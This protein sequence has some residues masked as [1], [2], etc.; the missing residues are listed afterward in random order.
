MALE[1]ILRAM[2]P[3]MLS[4]LAIKESAKEAWDAI[5]TMRMGVARVRKAKAQ[6]LRKEFDNLAFHDGES[7][8]DFAMRLTGL[9][10]NLHILGD[11]LEEEKVVQKFMCVV[12]PR[13]SQIALSIETLMDLDT[14]SVKE[15]TERLKAAEDRLDLGNTGGSGSR[16]L[17]T[18]EE[19]LAHMKKREQGE[20]SSGGGKPA[21]DKAGNGGGNKRR[22]KRHGKGGGKD[23]TSSSGKGAGK[24]K[25]YNCG[26]YGHFAREC[27][28]PRRERKEEANM[29]RAQEE[30]PTL[31]MAEHHVL[32]QATDGVQQEAVFLNEEKVFPVDA[33]SD[34][35]YL[36][37]GASNHM[38]GN[39]SSLTSLD[40]TVKGTVKFGDDSVVEICSK[41]AV[42]YQCK[43]Q[44]HRVL[45]EVYYIPRLRSNIISLGQL[46]ESGYKI[47]IE[48]G[49]LCI[50]DRE[51]LL[52]ARVLRSRN[53]L[54]T[55]ALNLTAPVCLLAKADDM[56]WRWHARYG[57]LHFR[58][59]HDLTAKNMVDGVP[60][61]DRVEKFCDGCALGKQH[62]A[63]FPR[64]SSYR[65]E[66]GLELVHGDLYGPITP[67]TPIGNQYFLLIVDDHSRYMW[68]E[69]LRTKDEAF[70]FFRKI[71]TLAENK[72]DVKLKAFR[73][74]RGGEFNSI[75]FGDYCDEHGIKRYTTAPYSPQQNGVVERRNQT[76]VEMAHSLLKSMRVPAMFWGEAVKTTVHILNR[77]PTRSLDGMTPYEAWHKRRPNVRCL[78][79]FGC[80]A[81]VKKVGPGITKLSDRSTPMV[82]I[83]YEEGAKA[84]RV[85]DPKTHKLHVTRDVVFEE[86]KQWDWEAMSINRAPGAMDT[87]FIEYTTEHVAD[88]APMN[89]DDGAAS[90]SGASPVAPQTA[91]PHTPATPPAAAPTDVEW[92]PPPTDASHDSEGAPAIPD[93]VRCLRHDIGP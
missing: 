83:G 43:N 81:H 31:L 71:K 33:G 85:Y 57:H 79:T 47:V 66:C 24:G 89:G 11:K 37:T 5:K 6:S 72:H 42:M 52:L 55:L 27:C 45:T 12:P 10:N 56:A 90:T 77:A 70:R 21:G 4:T 59:L 84:Y 13:Y 73:T 17:L 22:Y 78:R 80:V 7:I 41:G 86:E 40:E 60:M 48:G 8:D 25:C 64:A 88:G 67:A 44:E 65:A 20:N 54:Y 2:P 15:L 18:K 82:F 75:E 87:F 53:R 36:D 28:K 3:E 61:I 93:G 16:L 51:R 35:W 58:A 26:I 91:E 39:Q 76:T 9:V 68:V 32:V 38:T 74:D 29:S 46:D 23:A 49:E 1:A 69:M 30:Q 63:P 50:F 14:L 19:W 92:V 34:M 62:R